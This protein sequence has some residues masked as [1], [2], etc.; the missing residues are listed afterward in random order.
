MPFFHAQNRSSFNPRDF[1]APF[2]DAFWISHDPTYYVS[3]PTNITTYY[4]VSRVEVDMQP[5]A[6]AAP[7]Y[8]DP[9]I[10]Y[11]DTN[12]GGMRSGDYDGETPSG[13]DDN[14]F[15]IVIP[16]QTF[17]SPNDLHIMEYGDEDADIT[18][19][20]VLAVKNT[21]GNSEAWQALWAI[22]NVVGGTGGDYALSLCSYYTTGGTYVTKLSIVQGNVLVGSYTHINASQVVNAF[23]SMIVTFTAGSIY[24]NETKVV[25]MYGSHTPE[26]GVGMNFI[27]PYNILTAIGYVNY[28]YVAEAYLLG[29]R[30]D[31]EDILELITYFNNKYNIY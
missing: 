10:R 13:T 17:Q 12:F 1:I 27:T 7:P 22:Q 11:N 3:D 31:N 23:S 16:S 28:V 25:D 20:V 26:M 24:V 4:N 8:I 15:G 9:T 6:V 21:L 19:C 14:V 5:L 18:A 29:R 30:L 2:H